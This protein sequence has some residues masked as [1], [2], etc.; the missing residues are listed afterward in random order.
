MLQWVQFLHLH[1]LTLL[2]HIWNH[3]YFLK[4]KLFLVM[5]FC[6]NTLIALAML[7]LLG[8]CNAGIRILRMKYLFAAIPNQLTGRVN[9]LLNLSAVAGRILFSSVFALSLFSKDGVIYALGVFSF[10]FA[11][12]SATASLTTLWIFSFSCWVNISTSW[13]VRTSTLISSFSLFWNH[14]YYCNIIFEWNFV[15]IDNE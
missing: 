8:V 2:W 9:G 14:V 13:W 5:I 15:Y 10:I 3:Y 1:M 7:F 4:W 12:T 11:V 6:K